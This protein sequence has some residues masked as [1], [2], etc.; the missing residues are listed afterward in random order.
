MKTMLD[1]LKEQLIDGLSIKKAK[2]TN[3]KYK[4][5]FE[6]EGEETEAELPK[7]CSPGYHRDVCD[8]TIITAMSSLYFRKGD[9][10]NAKLWLDKITQKSTE[11]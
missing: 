1:Y 11:E 5:C 4:I 7:S 3:T 8:N 2:E 10:Q 6:Y 9:F